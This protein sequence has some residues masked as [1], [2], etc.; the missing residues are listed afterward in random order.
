MCEFISQPESVEEHP[1]VLE[2]SGF[3]PLLERDISA[4][5]ILSFK[6][7]CGFTLLKDAEEPMQTLQ[8]GLGQPLSSVL[9]NY[10]L[11]PKD[12]VLLAY[13]VARAYWQ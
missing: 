7:G 13:A 4:R 8:P 12:K 6:A 3:C 1:H 11:T 10:E 9:R 5:L 2:P